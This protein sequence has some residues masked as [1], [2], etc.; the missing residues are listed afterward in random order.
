MAAA[1]FG[2]GWQEREGKILAVAKE[3]GSQS[4]VAPLRKVL[5]RRPDRAFG[6]ADPAR[7]HYAG[8][9]DLTEALTEHDQLVKILQDFGA[10]VLFHEETLPDHADAI[11]VHDPVLVSDQ[12]AVMLKMGK[13]LRRGEE[14]AIGR[15]LE[16]A[17]VPIHYQ[18]HGDAVCEGGDLVWLDEATLAVGLGY[19]TNPQGLRQLGEA[20][21]GVTLIPVQLPYYLGPSACLHLM[22]TVSIVAED[23]AVVYRPLTSVVFLQE[24]E[25][26]GFRLIDVPEEEFAGMGPNVLALEPRN[27]VMLEGNPVTSQRLEAAGCS[28]TTYRGDHISLMAEGGATCLT[29]PILRG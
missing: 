5:V 26:R 29:R 6:G 10:E 11:F 2:R 25:Q 21:P 4:M 14:A 27:C 19:R 3:Y 17:G 23:L 1:I 16:K 9:P 7:W 24:L 8:R 15:S 20:L 18:V 22:S 13:E 12:G 28:V